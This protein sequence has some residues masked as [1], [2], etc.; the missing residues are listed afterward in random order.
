MATF[1]DVCEAFDTEGASPDSAVQ[2][3]FDGQH[4][5]LAGIHTTPTGVV[6]FELEEA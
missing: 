6:V 5:D 1:D 3:Q 2:F 4:F